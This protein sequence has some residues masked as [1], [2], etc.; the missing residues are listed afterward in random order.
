MYIY[1]LPNILLLVVLFFILKSTSRYKK[2]LR[3]MVLGGIIFANLSFLLARDQL[4]GIDEWFYQ[5]VVSIMSPGMTV[6]MKHI[7]NLGSVYA[8]V[9]IALLLFFLTAYHKKSFYGIIV[10]INLLTVWLMNNGLKYMFRRERPNILRIIEITNYSFPSGHAMV[11]MS[12]Y[13]FLAYLM[14]K[15]KNK[16][17]VKL[18]TVTLLAVII[19]LIGVSRIY[20]GVHYF[21]DVLA[22]CVFGWI[23]MIFMIV[24]VEQKYL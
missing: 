1:L 2:H 10:A 23:W 6:F 17:W 8:L 19:L 21:S 4:I 18:I 16:K 11:S 9:L 24:V 14:L 12:F 13:G 22:G 5:K 15:T 20:L 3:E 7:S